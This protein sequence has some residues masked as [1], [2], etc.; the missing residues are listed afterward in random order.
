MIFKRMLDLIS[1]M[2]EY[3]ADKIG[4]MRSFSY[5]RN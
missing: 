1:L 3:D 5:M 2:W 4:T